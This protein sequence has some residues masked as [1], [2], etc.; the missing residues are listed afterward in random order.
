MKS[1]ATQKNSNQKL[2]NNSKEEIKNGTYEVYVSNIR[3]L[4]RSE[5]YDVF[6][7][8]GEIENIDLKPQ[9][10]FGFVAFS[11]L[12]SYQSAIDAEEALIKNQIRKIRPSKGVSAKSQR[13]T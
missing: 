9:K 1:S 2:Q 12:E 6:V 4:K 3:G 7:T 10:G 13:T 11:E 8:Y 5:V